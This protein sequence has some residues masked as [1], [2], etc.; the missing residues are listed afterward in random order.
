ML[1][2]R[3]QRTGRKNIPT[4]RVV[5]TDSKNS[6]KS[7]KFLEILGNFD[8]ANDKKTI[9]AEK[10][11][12]WISKGAQLSD[13]MRNFLIDKKVIEGKKVNN[14]PRKTPI[15]KE[16]IK[17]EAPKTGIPAEKTE[18]KTEEKPSEA[19][20]EAKKEAP[21]EAPKA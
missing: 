10:I 1:M 7:G 6:A 8:L 4:F 14:L 19:P 13:T 3:L 9:D 15:K 5:L 16:E 2:I 17:A 20:K 21:T 12:H 18:A 11:K